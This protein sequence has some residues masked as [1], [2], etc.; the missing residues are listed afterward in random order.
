MLE[1]GQSVVASAGGLLVVEVLPVLPVADWQPDDA[2]SLPDALAAD[3]GGNSP[4]WWTGGR[5]ALRGLHGRTPRFHTGRSHVI[6]AA[7]SPR[8]GADS[9]PAEV[10][11][12]G[13]ALPG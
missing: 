2:A 4:R 10:L 13:L 11:L 9:P 7:S 12:G 3:G 5:L 6:P 8:T 1:R